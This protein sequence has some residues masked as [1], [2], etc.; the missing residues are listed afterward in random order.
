VGRESVHQLGQIVAGEAPLQGF[1]N[2]VP[3]ALELVERPRQRVEVLVV[4]WFEHFALEDRI[5]R[6]DTKAR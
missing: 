4:V 1:G 5:G 6:Q 2:R 3:V